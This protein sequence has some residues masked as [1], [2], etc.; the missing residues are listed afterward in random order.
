LCVIIRQLPIWDMTDGGEGG[1]ILSQPVTETLSNAVGG[2]RFLYKFWKTSSNRFFPL[3]ITDRFLF[4]NFSKVFE[5]VIF[6]RTSHYF[7]HKL[8]R[9]IVF[10]LSVSC[11]VLCL[12]YLPFCWLYTR[13]LCCTASTLMNWN[14]LNLII[15][16]IIRVSYYFF[17]F[18]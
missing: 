7:E 17:S 8:N 1:G 16:T 4:T 11:F 9:H 6:D 18:H 12:M 10:V 2:K 15:I 5:F 13:D 3:V 14:G